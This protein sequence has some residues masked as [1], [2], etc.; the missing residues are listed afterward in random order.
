MYSGRIVE[1]AAAKRIFENPLHPYTK[2]LLNS[3]PANNQG[4]ELKTINGQPPNIQEVISGCRFN[5]RCEKMIDKICNIKSPVLKEVEP[6]H[7]VE[8]YLYEYKTNA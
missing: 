8:C 7:L 6:N 5:P 3:L 2:A 4:R 1:K